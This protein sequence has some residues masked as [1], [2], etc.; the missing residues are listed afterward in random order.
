MMFPKKE[1][2]RV[3][4]TPEGEIKLDLLGRQ[5]GRGAY[6]CKNTE[7]LEKAVKSKALNRSFGMN[8]SPEIYESLREELANESK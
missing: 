1:L 7:C 2:I 6:L 8:I 4:L 5:N 3:L